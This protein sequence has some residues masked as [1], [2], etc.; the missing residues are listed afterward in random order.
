LNDRNRHSLR[1]IRDFEQIRKLATR[2]VTRPDGPSGVWRKWLPDRDALIREAVDCWVPIE[3]LRSTLNEMP[4][5]PLTTS[6]VTGRL[7]ALWE[8]GLDRPDE[9][10]KFECEELYAREK[11]AGT[12]LRAI[13]A[14]M[15]DWIGEQIRRQMNADF[16][17]RR[18]RRAESRDAAEQIFLSGADCNW[19]Q[20]GASPNSYCRMNGRIYRLSRAPDKKLEVHRVQSMDD[21]TGRLIGRYQGRPE[22]TKAVEQV[23]YQPE[24]RRYHGD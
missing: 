11:S 8:E 7:V 1:H 23:A 9:A 4:G 15:D 20:I 3:D 18:R 2:I 10:F 22:A 17:E 21:D 6:D 24:P 14:I 5:P 13:V 12:E 19:T 16:E